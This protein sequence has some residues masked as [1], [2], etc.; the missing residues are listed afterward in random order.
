MYLYFFAKIILNY[1]RGS[2]GALPDA[3]LT[4]QQMINMLDKMYFSVT[5]TSLVRSSVAEMYNW[6]VAEIMKVLEYLLRTLLLDYSCIFDSNCMFM[7]LEANYKT[8]RLAPHR[9]AG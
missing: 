8:C 6:L 7:Y 4:F 5:S 2:K 1:I 3:G 9:L